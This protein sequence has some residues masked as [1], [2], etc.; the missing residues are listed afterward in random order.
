MKQWL[1]LILGVVLFVMG[2][3]WVLQGSNAV[4]NSPMSGHSQWTVIGA[5]LAVA[6]VVLF[7]GGVRKLLAGRR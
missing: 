6:G 3:V 2:G 5:I 1:R 4:N 7:V